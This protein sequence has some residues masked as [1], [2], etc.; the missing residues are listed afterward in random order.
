MSTTEPNTT[1]GLWLTV[2]DLARQK[3]LTKSTVSERLAKFVA[4]R[5]VETRKGKGR[6]VLINV[7]QFDR[8]AGQTTDFA[9]QAGHDTRRMMADE[10]P[11]PP[12]DGSPVYTAEQAK[13]M[14]YRAEMARL[15]L[16]V[17]QGNLLPVEAISEAA[18]TLAESLVRALDQL[19]SIADD[20]AD[21]VARNGTRG[22]HSVLKTKARDI[23]E[24]MERGLLAIASNAQSGPETGEV[25]ASDEE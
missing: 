13:H 25:P 24:I 8:A 14:S 21:A 6:A 9:R 7:A 20:I 17:R 15:D 22:A 18:T 2:S 1:G 11:S 3:G 16:E 23:R 5:L 10:P 19:P 12:A 4:A